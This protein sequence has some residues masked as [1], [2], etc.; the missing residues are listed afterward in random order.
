MNDNG[1]DD[2]DPDSDPE[3]QSPDRGEPEDERVTNISVED[4]PNDSDR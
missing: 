3:Y 1:F 2:P 4:Q